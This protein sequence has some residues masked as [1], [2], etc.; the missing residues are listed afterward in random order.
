MRFLLVVLQAA[1]LRC[2]SRVAV[3]GLQRVLGGV[4][5]GRGGHGLRFLVQPL[6]APRY[7]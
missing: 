7:G 2:A 3:P 1:R 4:G 5:P 6:G